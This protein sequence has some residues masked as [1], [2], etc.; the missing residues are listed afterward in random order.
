MPCSHKQQYCFEVRE[1]RGYY[2]CPFHQ[3]I[4]DADPWIDFYQTGRHPT[5]TRDRVGAWCSTRRES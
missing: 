2:F 4:V 5:P 1:K 3:A